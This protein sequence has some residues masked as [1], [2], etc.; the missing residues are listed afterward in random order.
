MIEM[1]TRPSR[2]MTPLGDGAKF[3]VV[4]RPNGTG[5]SLMLVDGHGFSRVIAHSVVS[6]P[7]AA[8]LFWLG[9]SAGQ[10][11]DIP[12]ERES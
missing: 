9:W 7:D 12:S 4:A 8:D 2:I 6:D 3:V 5:H 11:H 10:Y 1:E